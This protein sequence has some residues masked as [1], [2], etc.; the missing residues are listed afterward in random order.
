MVSPFEPRVGSDEAH[1]RDWSTL[2]PRAAG[3]FRLPTETNS[4]LRWWVGASHPL[5]YGRAGRAAG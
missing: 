2:S 1:S 5:A 4:Y 3:H